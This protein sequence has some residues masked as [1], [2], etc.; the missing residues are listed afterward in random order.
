MDS[1]FR[2]ERYIR[3]SWTNI[4][5]MVFHVLTGYSAVIAFSTSIFE[6]ILSGPDTITPEQGTYFIGLASVCGA[7]LGIL[8]VKN[9]GRRT[10]LLYG[11]ATMAAIHFGI[12]LCAIFNRNYI[13]IVL[14]NV[15]LLVYLTTSGPVAWI[16]SAETCTDSTLGVVIMTLWLCITLETS[17]SKTIEDGIG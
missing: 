15:F 11:H 10:L 12:A 2:D 1:L 14:I 9:V 4:V 16:Y 6:D 17:T 7:M 13:L 3:A 5:I 8:I